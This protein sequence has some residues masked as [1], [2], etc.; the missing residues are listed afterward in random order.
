MAF[1][2][3]HFT[4]IHLSESPWRVPW[5]ALL[6][7]RLVGW[8]NLALLGRHA[9]LRDGAEVTA[10]LIR[11]LEA[12]RPDHVL[13]TGDATALALP[14][15]FEG[16]RRALAPLIERGRVTGIP[17]NHDLY[18]RSVLRDGL[19]E[20]LLGAWE[21]S[22]WPAPP[23]IVRLLGDEVALLVLKDARPTPLHDSTG[24]VGEEQLRKLAAILRD[25]RLSKRTRIL[26][27]HYGPRRADGRPDRRLHALRDA[28][29][30]L[31]VAA[32]GGVDLVVHG[33]LHDRFVLGRGQGTPL[34]IANPG[35]LT[36]STMARA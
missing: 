7:K 17:G 30:L 22:D 34:P 25:Q 23:P 15:E 36:Y 18:V 8:L 29:R 21:R 11:D 19:Y 20:R 24:L 31:A 6:S 13:F 28:D 27:L 10:A 1:R 5:R 26:A 32:A 33:H 16:A 2:L 4:D 35:S 3:A 14:S 12:L 9:H